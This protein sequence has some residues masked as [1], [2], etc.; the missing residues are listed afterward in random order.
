MNPNVN[1]GFS[2]IIMY[3]Y[4]LTNNNR[5]T[6]PVQGVN[7]KGK[8]GGVNQGA[9]RNPVLCAIFF[10]KPKIILKVKVC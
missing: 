1:Y 3:Q 2:L 5:C 7:N 4:W 6:T 8:W 9:Y 10:Y